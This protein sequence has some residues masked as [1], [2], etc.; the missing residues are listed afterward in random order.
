[1]LPKCPF[2][3]VDSHERGLV[4]GHVQVVAN[5]HIGHDISSYDVG[6]GVLRLGIRQ[7]V[8]CRLCREEALLLSFFEDHEEV[9]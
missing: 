1:M 4:A 2:E 8:V 9:L 7:A 3:S 6:L 5:R